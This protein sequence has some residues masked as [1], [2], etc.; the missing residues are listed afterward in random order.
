MKN[1]ND[2]KNGCKVRCTED[3]SVYECIE[4]RGEKYLAGEH[5]MW[6]VS[7]FDLKDF[8]IEDTLL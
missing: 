4:W 6:S 1:W 8:E 3:N 2:I 5:D 7:E